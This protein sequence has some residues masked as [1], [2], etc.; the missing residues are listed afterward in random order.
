[1]VLDQNILLAKLSLSLLEVLLLLTELLLLIFEGF[2]DFVHGATLL[3]EP[4]GWRDAIQLQM[5]RQFDFLPVHL[6]LFK[7]LLNN[8]PGKRS[9]YN[10]MDE[11]DQPTIPEP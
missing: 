9:A 3:K 1:M 11:G 5:L 8:C 4:G 10:L 7:T 6:I 2:L